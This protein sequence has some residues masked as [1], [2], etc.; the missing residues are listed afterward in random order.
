MIVFPK[1]YDDYVQFYLDIFEEYGYTINTYMYEYNNYEVPSDILLIIN[2]TYNEKCGWLYI[3]IHNCPCCPPAGFFNGSWI[4]TNTCDIF[5]K[6]SL[7]CYASNIPKHQWCSA[8]IYYNKNYNEG[9]DKTVIKKFIN[10]YHP[11]EI[12]NISTLMSTKDIIKL[13]NTT[14]Y[15]YPDPV[16]DKDEWIEHCIENGEDYLLDELVEWRPWNHSKYPSTYRQALQTICILA[17]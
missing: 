4:E 13:I 9:I 12:N 6:D 3:N 2:I 16:I 14:K 11:I 8:C 1:N 17:H 7:F 10:E 15:T 5:I